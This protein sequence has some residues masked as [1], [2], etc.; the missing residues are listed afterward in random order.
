MHPINVLATCVVLFLSLPSHAQEIRVT[1]TV[2][3]SSGDL[4]CFRIETPTATYYLETTGA[5]LSSMIDAD[6]ND[7]LSFHPEAGSGARGEYRGFPNA[8]H[9]QDGNYFHARN[10]GTDR[11]TVELVALEADRVTFVATSE[12]ETWLARWDFFAT[13]CTFTMTQIPD[14]YAYWI[15]YEGT[16]GGVFDEHGWWMTSAI[17]SPQPIHNPHEGDIPAPEWIAFGNHNT[18]R[19]LVLLQH[20]DDDATDRY[21]PMQNSMT[22]FGFG[23]DGMAKLLKSVPRS[24]SIGIVESTTHSEI[25]E[26]MEE[27]LK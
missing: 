17:D 20:E 15:L 12:S 5:G 18:P 4:P 27:L 22:V 1:K 2:D 19:S 25:A 3:P 10:R 9:Q 26:R 13:H 16:P 24:F 23:R 8:V 7:W 6:G 11:S 14:G 21:Y